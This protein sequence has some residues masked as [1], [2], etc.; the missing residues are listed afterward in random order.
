MQC[1]SLFLYGR[2]VAPRL[3][4]AHCRQDGETPAMRTCSLHEGETATTLCR[5]GLAFFVP[6]GGPYGEEANA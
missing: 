1:N 6:T 2:G 3:S 5:G 4:E